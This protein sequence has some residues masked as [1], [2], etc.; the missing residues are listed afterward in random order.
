MKD[1]TY[2]GHVIKAVFAP[3]SKSEHEAVCLVLTN[4]KQVRLRQ[5]AGDPFFDPELNALVGKQIKA[6]GELVHGN[7]LLVV[8]WEELTSAATKPLA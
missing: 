8:S 7:T 1:K 3:G 5:R 2:R 4:G 6:L